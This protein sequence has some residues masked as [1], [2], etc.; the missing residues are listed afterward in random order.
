MNEESV[1][2]W[3]S[4]DLESL[5]A[6]PV[7]GSTVGVVLYDNLRDKVFYCAPGS[8]TLRS[9]GS[10]GIAYLNPRP[11]QD[12]IQHAYRVYY[13]H[14]KENEA[15][16]GLS[17]YSSLR[18]ALAN[19]YKNWKFG[20]RLEPALQLGVLAAHLLPVQ[21]AI[22]DRQFRHLPRVPEHGRVLDV[23]FG[24][25]GFLEN[26]L[27]MGWTAVGTDLDVKVVESARERGLDVHVGTVQQVR[28]PFD[29]ITMCHVIEHLHDPLAVLRRC[30][31]LLAPGGTLW[32]E[33]P[34][35]NALGH[36]RF[37]SDW[38]GLEPPRH[39]VLFS[40]S[41]LAAVLRRV[42]FC[43]ISSLRQPSSV[44]G[45]WLMSSQI[46]EGLDRQREVHL[47][48]KLRLELALFRL[49]EWLWPD[50]REFIAV[51]AKKP[52]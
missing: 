1:E 15:S 19:G 9:C 4:E 22:A 50:R 18:R 38:R 21:R 20:T 51:T 27:S 37:G 45:M 14:K 30:Y 3:P 12:T 35:I 47:R 5:T 48:S 2:N 34:N 46:R 28:G 29:A 36:M 13:T 26:A 6:C 44:Y 49:L 10:C 42:G 33:T 17:F 11:T 24:D 23:G 39:L 40:R 43:D 32:I 8:W 41:S 31:E 16:G 25:D 7:C 52:E